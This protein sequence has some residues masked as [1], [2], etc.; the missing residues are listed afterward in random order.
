M[1]WAVRTTQLIGDRRGLDIHLLRLGVELR[2]RW[3]EHNIRQPP[4]LLAV[5]RESTRITGEILAR[6]ELERID[7]NAH[8]HALAMASRQANQRE[9]PVMQVAHGRNEGDGGFAPQPVAQLLNGINDLHA[10]NPLAYRGGKAR[11][12]PRRRIKNNALAPG[13]P[14]FSPLRHNFPPPAGRCPRRRGNSWRTWGSCR[15][16]SPACRAAPAPGRSTP[17]RRRCRWWG[18]PACP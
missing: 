1:P 12:P 4:E 16:R 8:D 10:E 15:G 9:M 2:H 3:G 11:K 7:E 17:D 14:R 6:P 13:I 18:W 5:F